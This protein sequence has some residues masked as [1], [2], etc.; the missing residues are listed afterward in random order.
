MGSTDSK[1]FEEFEALSSSKLLGGE[2]PVYHR[3]SPRAM[4]SD[5][6]RGTA[7]AMK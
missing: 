3:R 4:E 5:A 7:T 6:R 1:D 2:V